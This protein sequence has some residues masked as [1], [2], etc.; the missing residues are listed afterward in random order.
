MHTRSS[1]R[2]S[3]KLLLVAGMA[4]GVLLAGSLTAKATIGTST[5]GIDISLAPGN[6]TSAS[7]VITNGNAEATEIEIEIVDFERDINGAVQILP[8]NSIEESLVDYISV[9]SDRITLD[10][11]EG[12]TERIQFS[13]NLPENEAGPHWA[14][15]LVRE[16]IPDDDSGGG[17][18]AVGEVGL[19]FGIQIRQEDPTS[20]DNDGRILDVDVQFPEDDN[21][22]QVIADYENVGTTF[23]H[24]SGELRIVDNA[25]NIVVQI[26]IAPFRTLPGRTRR[27]VV[28]V[29]ESLPAGEYLA[30][31]IIDFDA[32]FLLA[33][34]ARFRIP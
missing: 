3:L 14:L 33:G 16:V 7:F 4:V 30:L 15:M 26:E 31:A 1:L 27:L 2:F 10:P 25:G 20:L 29:L 6:S 5:L 21:P 18:G 8:P 32:D 23:Q 13:I 17:P 34:Q 12:S 22:L 19:Q 24:A 9:A 28:D 11:G